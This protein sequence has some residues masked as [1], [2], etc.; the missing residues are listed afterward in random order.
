MSGVAVAG[1]SAAHGTTPVLHDVDLDVADGEMGAVLGPSGS[2]K[3]TLLRV[4]A[5]LHRPVS[6]TVWI[7]GREVSGPS[8]WVPPERRRVGL[9]P[10]TGSLFPHLSVADNVGFGLRRASLGAAAPRRPERQARVAAL[11]ELA[12]LADL[13][14]RFPHQ[15]SGGQ[16]QR[17]ALVRALAPDPDVVLLD[18]P[19]AALDAGLRANLRDEVRRILRLAGATA[20]LV[21][22]DQA[23]ALSFADRLWVLR[24]GRVAQTGTPHQ[25]YAEPATTWVARFLGEGTLIGAPTDGRTAQ[26]PWGPLPHNRTPAGRVELLLR[27]EQVVI[28]PVEGSRVAGEVV[29]RRFLG[30]ESLV[31]V[32][33][34]G[35]GRDRPGRDC[36][37]LART[38]APQAPD[39]GSRVGVRVAGSVRA[40]E[41][42][43]EAATEPPHSG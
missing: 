15:L 13:A 33:V 26:T 10:Q 25:L 22:H 16:Q 34:T 14:H 9:V 4:V 17:V 37:V 23:E 20:L 28:G 6:G 18:E 41:R 36:V 31:S 24:E 35:A 21:T 11:L 42:S 27:P 30:H 38:T 40:F 19:F 2:G 3:T 5:G 39:P 12:G 1:L 43:P 8:A 32:R 29:G 7:G